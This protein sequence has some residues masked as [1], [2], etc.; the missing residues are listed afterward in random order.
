MHEYS[1]VQSL[2]ARVEQEAAARGATRVRRL[3]VR[4]GELAGVDVD[5]LLTAY[6]TFRER[7]ICDGAEMAVTQVA[8][9]W[10]CP[11]CNVL[12]HPGSVL[13]CTAC[14]LPASLTSGDEI[15]L[16]RIEMEVRDV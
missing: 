12:I 4:I 7:S 3:Q 5:L 13:R 14:D 6:E 15:Y 1:I 8:A 9:E 2:L 16:D 11:H 10:R